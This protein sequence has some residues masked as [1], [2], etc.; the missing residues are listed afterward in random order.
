M[1]QNKDHEINY[2]IYF[3]SKHSWRYNK[4]DQS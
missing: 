1:V 4:L 2:E 3:R